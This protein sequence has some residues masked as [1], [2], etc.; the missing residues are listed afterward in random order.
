MT[1]PTIKVNRTIRSEQM[2]NGTTAKV[3][4]NLPPEY[5]STLV[6]L[7]WRLVGI[8]FRQDLYCFQI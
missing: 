3:A 8:T 4:F 6:N 5:W 2:L 7:R 1:K